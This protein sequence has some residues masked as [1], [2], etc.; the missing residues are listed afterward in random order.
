MQAGR[1]RVLLDGEV[2]VDN[3]NPT[4]RSERSTGM[5]S[6]ELARTIDL[7]AGRRYE[8]VVEAI[9]G[10]ARA[11]WSVGRAA[12]RRAAD[13]LIERAV[14][15]ARTRRRGRLRRRLRRR[16]GRPKGNDRESMTLPGAQ[17]ELVHAVA[18]V[19]P[20]TIVV[21]NAASPVDDAVG[22]RRR[23]GAPVLVRG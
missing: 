12:S 3:W 16:S 7:V 2:F 4:E 22:G 20:R 6:A 5:G 15:A 18:A 1:A 17:D 11:R 19:N 9:P 23:R 8:L 14:A 13:D 21:V 10:R